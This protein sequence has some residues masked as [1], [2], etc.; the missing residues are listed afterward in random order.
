MK[1]VSYVFAKYC[2]VYFIQIDGSVALLCHQRCGNYQTENRIFVR[3]Q[4]LQRKEDIAD[5]S[6]QS[7]KDLREQVTKLADDIKMCEHRGCSHVRNFNT[8]SSVSRVITQ[9]N[10]H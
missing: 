7:S 10:N 2:I 5:E 9:C 8:V 3:S 1:S 4:H 6:L